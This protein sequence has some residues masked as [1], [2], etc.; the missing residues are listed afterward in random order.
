[1]IY[2]VFNFFNELELLEIRL[3]ELDGLADKHILVESTKTFQNNPKELFYEKNK[4]Q[5]KKWHDKIVHVVIEDSPDTSDSWAV[6]YFQ[7]NCADRGLPNL[8]NDDVIMWCCTD[9]IPKKS[10]M[11]EWVKT[12]H[13]PAM[14][15]QYS[16][17]GYLNCWNHLHDKWTGGR[18]MSGEQW[19]ASNNK[20]VDF[21][22]DWLGTHIQDC[23]WHFCNMGGLDRYKLKIESYGHKELNHEAFKNSLEYK[24]ICC[25]NLFDPLSGYTMKKLPWDQMPEYVRNNKERFAGFLIP[26]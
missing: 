16:C 23:G 12:K 2:D 14:M 13:H 21:R 4:E 9:E 8:Q 5:F 22:K 10:V 26:D 18:V 7:F 3:N 11:Q 17:G 19:K 6:E 24:L 1:M 15:M 20:Y 25:Y